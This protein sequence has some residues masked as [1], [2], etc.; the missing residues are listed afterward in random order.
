MITLYESEQKYAVLRPSIDSVHVPSGQREEGGN[1]MY[2]SIPLHPAAD[3]KAWRLEGELPATL[4]YLTIE[5][6]PSGSAE[7]IRLWID[8][9][10]IR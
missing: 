9:M 4:N 3:D 8:A 7:L 5:F 1:W 2:R 10:A 6:G